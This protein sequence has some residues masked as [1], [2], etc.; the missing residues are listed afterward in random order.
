MKIKQ[1]LK[2][3]SESIKSLDK[4]LLGYRLSYVKFLNIIPRIPSPDKE[5][6]LLFCVD[7]HY[8]PF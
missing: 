3:I 1:N 2:D 5:K 4:N 6:D 7:H 8:S